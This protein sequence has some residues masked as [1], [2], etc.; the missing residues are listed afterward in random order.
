MRE[1]Y[2]NIISTLPQETDTSYY[3]W[4]GHY[5]LKQSEGMSAWSCPQTSDMPDA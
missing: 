2:N 3:A 1:Q 4:L 5:D